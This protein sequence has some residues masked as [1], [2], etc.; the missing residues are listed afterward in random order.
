MTLFAPLFLLGLIAIGLPI[1][2]HRLSSENPN[3][4]AFSSL[5][6]LEPGEPRRVLAKN[7]QYLLLLA[8][9]IGFLSLLVLAFT[10]PACFR[11]P[12]AAG[13][14]G[15][16]LHLVVLDTSASMAEGDRWARAQD[17]AEDI[18]GSLSQDDLAQVIAVSRTA[19]LL[20]QQTRDAA[21]LRA[22]IDTAAPRAFRLDFGQMM[23]TLDGVLRS[24]DLPVAIHI[25]TDAQTS[26]LPNRFADLAPG[27]PASLE[28]INVAASTTPGNWAIES[29]GGSPV[30]GE[31]LATVRSYASTETTQT[32]RLELEGELIEQQDVVIP[33]GGSAVVEFEPLALRAGSNRVSVAFSRSDPLPADN[34][35]FIALQRPEPRPVLLVTGDLRGQDALFTVAALDTLEALVIEAVTVAPEALNEQ[36]LA[37]QHFVVVTDAGALSDAQATQLADY[38]Q[39]GG[40]VMLALGPRSTGLVRVPISGQVIEQSG[41]GEQAAYTSIGMIDAGHPA[42]RGVEALRGARYFRHINVTPDPADAVLIGLESGNAL[43]L[44][45]E[46]GAGRVLVYTS[47]LDRQWNDLVVQPAFV[48]FMS[49]LANH[50]LGSAG[51]TSEAP[52]GSTL[53]VRAMGLL[54]GQ[55]FDASGNVA[56]GLGGTEDVLLDQIGYYEVVG[57]GV[58]S[59][60]AVNFDTRESDLTSMD[61]AAIERW[62]LLGIAPGSR[63]AAET[64][65]GNVVPEQIPLGWWLLA[66]L[67]GLIVVE[68]WAGNWHLRVQRGIA[69]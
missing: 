17:E 35:R 59:F 53:A 18:I 39:S 38:V 12:T 50:M 2:L 32:V 1:W 28:I 33:P 42:L 69:S 23:G 43:L 47:T 21:V 24:A 13:G 46:L 41:L 4:Q 19:E 3:K 30:T 49:G 37:A 8:L 66:A 57:N 44:E 65:G 29:L 26:G 5:M 6:F 62:Q 11:T 64:V 58:A 31:L 34:T 45:R 14:N 20:T 61:S 51:F 68:T 9:R 25:V 52:L 7:L 67:V 40:V 27:G 15:A 56:L 63:I 55:I 22:A 54:G 16:A 10:G 60:I 36:D 48:P